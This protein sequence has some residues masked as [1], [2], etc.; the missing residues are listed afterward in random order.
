VHG[1]VFVEQKKVEEDAIHLLNKRWNL[2]STF[3]STNP[4][5]VYSVVIASS[6]NCV[7]TCMG[8][9]AGTYVYSLPFSFN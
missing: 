8:E 2:L 3:F 9:P 7:Y 6:D 5:Q 4:A 1:D